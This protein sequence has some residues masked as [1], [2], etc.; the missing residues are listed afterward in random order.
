[1]CILRVIQQSE[2]HLDKILNVD[3]F[4]RRIFGVIYSNDPV[5]KAITIRYLALKTLKY[6]ALKVKT[7]KY[8]A[9][10]T[11]KYLALKFE[12]TKI[13][14]T[15]NTKIS[16]TEN[17]KTPLKSHIGKQFVSFH[18]IRKIFLFIFCTEVTFSATWKRQFS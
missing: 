9:L 15:E 3:E 18:K 13:F 14:C 10:K 17:T 16:C 12:N 11:L 7:L 2:R 4:M 1:L 8:L 6:L 5:A